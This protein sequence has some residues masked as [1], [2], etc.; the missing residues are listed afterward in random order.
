MKFC[1]AVQ[2]P[3]HCPT[4]HETRVKPFIEPK[5]MLVLCWLQTDVNNMWFRLLNKVHVMIMDKE[6]KQ[7]MSAQR[8]AVLYKLL[9][10]T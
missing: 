10:K 1:L 8:H 2:I 4:K 6:K 5:V 3:A 9:E 7:M